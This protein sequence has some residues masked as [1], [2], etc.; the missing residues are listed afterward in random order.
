MKL[1]SQMIKQRAQQLG[2]DL[3]G[4]ASID[5]YYE[6]PPLMDPKNYFPAA[7]SV[8]VIA[9][10]IPRGSYRGI[11]EGTHWHN[12]TY[13]SYNRL[14]TVIRPR[15]TYQLAA[16]IEDFGW[17]AVP[18][19]PGVPERNP[20][21][22]PVAEGKL[23]ADIVMQIRLMGVGAGLGEMGHSKV[24]LTPEFGPRQR[25]GMILTDAELEPDPILQPGTVCN[26]CGGC[27][28]ECPGNAVPPVRDK[29]KR[30]TVHIG[31]KTI[32][33]GDVHMGRCTLTHHGFNNKI[34]PFHK[35]AFPNME[36]DVDG[37]QVTEEEAYRICYP[38]ATASWS[39][40]I[41]EEGD[42]HVIKYYNYVMN[43][44]GYFA[45][46]GAKGCI[47]ACMMNLEKAGRIKN[48]FHHEFR[49]KQPWML[50]NT[51][52]Q[53]QGTINPF[54]EEYLDEHYPGIRKHEQGA[55]E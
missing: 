51:I 7:K 38:M 26:Q 39:D 12:Y 3:V 47:R 15:L 4:I 36:F 32:S 1:T 55:E 13:Y 25:L 6:A 18:C 52:E 9:M 40:A 22:P 8:I 23:P 44:V 17:E 48:T 21:R 28:R 31:D 34:S 2:I 5:R 16:F 20:M 14:N 49:Y 50:S 42:A 41:Y 35:K 45:V 29:A 10:R 46:C 37:A 33:W 43:H 11:E 27:V 53:Q 24:F 30:I 54:R 19:Y